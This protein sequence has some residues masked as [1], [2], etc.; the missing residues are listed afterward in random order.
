M[1]NPYCEFRLNLFLLTSY[2][3]FEIDFSGYKNLQGMIFSLSSLFLYTLAWDW[4]MQFNLFDMLVSSHALPYYVSVKLVLPFI[5][6][7][8]YK[9][10]NFQ[11]KTCN[12]TN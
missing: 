9:S 12:Y 4:S 7:I 5:L 1:M 3:P 2:T 10:N 6:C 11:A 8:L